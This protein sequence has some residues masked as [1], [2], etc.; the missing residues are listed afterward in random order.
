MTS[1]SL[2]DRFT[3][4]GEWWLPETPEH[5]VRGTLEFNCSDRITLKLSG[6]LYLGSPTVTVRSFSF[7]IILGIT[8][9]GSPC[10][11]VNALETRSSFSFS[12]D[13]STSELSIVRLL[14]GKHYSSA[15]EIN[16]HRLDIRLM[17]LNEWLGIAPI[18]LTR[19]DEGTTIKLPYASKDVLEV[20]LPA[21]E[22]A[23]RIRS[24]LGWGRS[25]A[26]VACHHSA[27]MVV[28]PNKPRDYSWFA[29]HQ[30]SCEILFTL[31]VGYPV[32]ATEIAGLVEEDETPGES[33][34]TV[35]RVYYALGQF[36]SKKDIH[37]SEILVPLG[38]IKE[39]A[40]AIIGRWLLNQEALA[41]VHS[42]FS[43]VHYERRMYVEAEF[44]TLAQALEIFHRRQRGGNY[45][46]GPEY[47]DCYQAL[48]QALPS[49]VPSPLR[50]RLIEYLK[51][52]NE[53]SLRKR[54]KELLK[55]ISETT[56]KKL[57]PDIDAFAESVV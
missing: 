51:Y 24:S 5:R 12:T 2:L 34:T 50:D 19:H 49:T 21:E 23:I 18:E 15:R 38:L 4:D 22:G 39:S 31:L 20:P 8:L 30:R 36:P 10:T 43:T 32:Y 29:K 45:V 27:S 26:E 54:V 16:F 57:A 11:L 46:S 40:Q 13:M 3:L 47:D 48:L 35:V 7:P 9:D 52:G 33:H 41:P 53:Y 28:H 37:P 25:F 44:L 17:Y 55:G 1:Q 6:S 14:V 56:R 42:L